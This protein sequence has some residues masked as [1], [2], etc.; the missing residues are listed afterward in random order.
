MNAVGWTTS[1]IQKI[2]IRPPDRDLSTLDLSGELF[3]RLVFL[4]I[5]VFPTL[6]IAIGIAIYVS[7]KSR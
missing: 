6:L 2:S 7:R 3:S 4:S 5:D 1:Q